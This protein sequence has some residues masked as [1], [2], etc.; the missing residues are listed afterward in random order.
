MEEMARKRYG[1]IGGDV[2][3]GVRKGEAEYDK[4]ATPSQATVKHMQQSDPSPSV[5][6][7]A[8]SRSGS[9][10]L[11]E[12]EPNV[13]TNVRM[14]KAQAVVPKFSIPRD[15]PETRHRG[16]NDENFVTPY[17]YQSRLGSLS[18]A[19]RMMNLRSEAPASS[20]K[21][22]NARVEPDGLARTKSPGITK[23]TKMGPPASRTR[24]QQQHMASSSRA[25]PTRVDTSIA[26]LSSI[27]DDNVRPEPYQKNEGG[28]HRQPPRLSQKNLRPSPVLL[29]PHPLPTGSHILSGRAKLRVHARPSPTSHQVI[30]SIVSVKEKLVVLDRGREL[31]IYKRSPSGEKEGKRVIRLEENAKWGKAEEAVWQAVDGLMDRLKR[32]TVKVR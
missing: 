15:T 31:R 26:N 4:L 24:Q 13:Q 8:A 9:R 1:N 5:R 27:L 16:G 18:H 11:T 6:V 2:G 7:L 25:T 10:Q 32:K 17:R 22:K 12:A 3:F 21:A 14:V 28:S 29:D 19:P 20:P 30:L 23:G